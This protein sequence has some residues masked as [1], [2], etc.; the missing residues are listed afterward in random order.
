MEP[1]IAIIVAAALHFAGMLLLTLSLI[2]IAAMAYHFSKNRIKCVC[3]PGTKLPM[4]PLLIAAGGL[5]FMYLTFTYIQV[6]FMP[7]EA[8]FTEGVHLRFISMS[9]TVIGGLISFYGTYKFYQLTLK[10]KVTT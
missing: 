7:I 2:H 3:F 9:I 8:L 6:S 1:S 10:K 4:Y 5:T